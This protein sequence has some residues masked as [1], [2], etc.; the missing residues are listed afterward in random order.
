MATEYAN[1]CRG[2]TK[3]VLKAAAY[4]IARGNEIWDSQRVPVQGAEAWVQHMPE[5]GQSL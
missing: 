5:L 1:G 4:F 3:C 2:V